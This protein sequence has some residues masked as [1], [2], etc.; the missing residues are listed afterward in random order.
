[1]SYLGNNPTNPVVQSTHQVLDLITFNG[2]SST[3]AL[4]VSGVAQSVTSTANVIITV[5]GVLQAPGVAYNISGTN[6]VFTS[7][8]NSGASFSGIVLGNS[9]ETNVPLANSVGPTQLQFGAVD[10]AGDKVT[11]ILP[12]VDGGTGATTTAAAR[13]SLGA[14]ATLVSGTS[15]KT[16]NSVSLLGSGNIALD[17]SLLRSERTSNT[18]ISVAN[19]G[20]FIDITSGTFTQ[21]FAAATTLGSGWYCYLKNSG[22]G[23]ITL[24]P[25]GSELIDGLNGFVMYPDECRLLQCDGVALRSIVINK[26]SKVFLTSGIFTVP[27]GYS[28]FDVDGVGGGQGGQGG[29]GGSTSINTSAGVGG[30]SGVHGAGGAYLRSVIQFTAFGSSVSALIG[31]GGVGS[32][33]SSGGPAYIAGSGG[34][35]SATTADGGSGGD[36]SLGTLFIAPGSSASSFSGLELGGALSG[37]RSIR[38]GPAGGDAAAGSSGGGRDASAPSPTTFSFSGGGAYSAVTTTGGGGI[39]GTNG[40]PGVASPST[41]AGT[42]GL[43]GG[44]GVSSSLFSGTA[45][46]GGGGG[47]GGGGGRSSESGGGAGGAGGAGGDGGGAGAGGGGGGGGGGSGATG[48]LNPAAANSAAAGGAGGAGGNGSA[49]FLRIMGA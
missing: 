35:L 7:V 16:L 9:Y 44:S 10:L 19:K 2:S 20:S 21:T 49:G 8:P 42:A 3:F 31:A 47:A 29:R 25:N 14:Q 48:G 17:T 6:I 30:F 46:G 41:T 4:T 1:M 11:G 36:T 26:F 43:A 22:T 24:D 37:Q 18:I 13:T 45:G 34:G 28:A 15:I 32:A 12:V 40:T 23:D 33:G 27:P 5:N 38:S 39:A